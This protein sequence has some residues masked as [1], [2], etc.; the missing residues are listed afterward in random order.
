MFSEA[1]PEDPEEW[2]AI[3]WFWEIGINRVTG[4]LGW[5]EAQRHFT[6]MYQALWPHCPD[7][8][9]RMFNISQ[10]AFY[11]LCW[12][13]NYDRWVA[14]VQYLKDNPTKKKIPVRTTENKH[15][16]MYN[17]RF[18]NQDG[19]QQRMGGWNMAGIERFN[20]IYDRI[21]AHKHIVP[22]GSPLLLPT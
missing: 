1:D 15:L 5:D 14:Q 22:I 16:Q 21:A 2:E 17:G 11:L 20:E 8:R 10:E 3:K 4:Q 6:T 12:E 13:N 7:A 19:G 18:T 9:A